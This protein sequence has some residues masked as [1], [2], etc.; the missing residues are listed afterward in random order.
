[1]KEV[2][3]KAKIANE[4]FVIKELKRLG[5]VFGAPI[6]QNDVIFAKSAVNFDKF[7]PNLI[8][9]RIREE[10]SLKAA[11]VLFTLKMPQKNEMDAI[12]KEIAIKEADKSRLIDI[13]KTLGYKE[14]IRVSKKRRKCRYKGYE[15]CIDKVGD[16]GDFIEMEKLTQKGG[17]EKIQ[18]EMMEFLR[19]L[20]VKDKDFIMRG[21]DTLMF[22]K[23]KRLD[24]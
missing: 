7:Q 23:Q 19:R 11:R 5:C 1:M 13:I 17:S 24:V 6:I 2:E 20:G 10:K 16:L 21:Y 14:I 15:I 22:V 3:A 8:T 4:N 12:E 18:K 9:L